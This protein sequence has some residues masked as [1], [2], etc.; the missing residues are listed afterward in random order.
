M[1]NPDQ[2]TMPD[3]PTTERALPAAGTDTPAPL[4]VR[5][6]PDRTM[7]VPSDRTRVRTN[8]RASN[9]AEMRR[10][11]EATRERMS[12]TLDAL[13]ARV[14][15]ERQSLERKKDDL[16][17]KATLKPL[18]EQLKREPWKSMAIA[19]VAGYVIAAIRD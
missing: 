1:P 9:P 8:G 18:R 3:S 12:G 17:D 4:E 11:I 10:E 2:H 5:S 19:F 13:E 15:R 16:V 7:S 6:V 14:S